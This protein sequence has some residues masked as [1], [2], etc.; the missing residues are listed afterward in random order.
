MSDKRL[1]AD[2]VRLREMV[3][4]KEIKVTWVEGTKQLADYLTKRGASSQR[5]LEVLGRNELF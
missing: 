4:T 5:P 3:D 2:I 1:R